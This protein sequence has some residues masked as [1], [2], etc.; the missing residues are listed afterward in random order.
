MRHR[1]RKRHLTCCLHSQ[2][3]AARR[4]RKQASLQ[5]AWQEMT[6]QQA[7]LP[8]YR[9][10]PAAPVELALDLSTLLRLTPKSP[11]LQFPR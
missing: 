6:M 2:H 11:A 10:Y 1:S 7:S 8:S 4:R 9:S 5:M 3:R